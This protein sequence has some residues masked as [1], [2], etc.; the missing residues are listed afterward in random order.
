MNKFEYK[1]L[2]PF[3]WYVLQNFPFIE[4][5]FDAITEYQLFCKVVEY[6][7]K[8][9][10]DM[11]AVG[12]QTEN[13]TNAMTELQDYVNNYFE[14]LDVQEEINNKLNEMVTDGTL[15]NIIENYINPYIQEQ[16]IRINNIETQVQSVAN[17]NP[18]PVSSIEDM[19]DTSRAYLLTT[20][21]NW[22]YYNGSA[23]VVGGNYQSTGIADNSI[24]YDMLENKLKN[25]FKASFNEVTGITWNTGGFYNDNGTITN[26]TFF[27]YT[28]KIPVNPYEYYFYPNNSG[29]RNLVCMY[30]NSYK[31]KIYCFIYFNKN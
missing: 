23:W 28:N 6:L 7:N 12:Q 2:S 14:N 4:A 18:I 29:P 3:K 10:D 16:N 5:D 27:A 24:Q 21:G 25:N 9:I 8:V 20:D 19:T 22:Y 1:R 11:N 31:Y 17:G 15:T 30:D 26:D 13:I